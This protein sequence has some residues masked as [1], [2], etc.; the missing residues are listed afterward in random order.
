MHSNSTVLTKVNKGVTGA[1]I[2]MVIVVVVAHCPA[3][4]VNVYTC[5]PTVDVLITEGDQIPVI[6]SEFVEL[7]GSVP[8]VA[9]L[10]IWS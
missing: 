6:G 7:V 2:T 8:G 4:G 10:T 9:F 1:V 3:L 5:E